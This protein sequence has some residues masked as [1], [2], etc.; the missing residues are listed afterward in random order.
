MFTHLHVH[1]EYSLLDGCCRIGQL[2]HKAKDLG[3]HS[4]AI[5]DH[6][7]MYGVIDFYKAAREEGIKP[8]LGCEVYV[9]PNDFRS[10]DPAEKSNC[11]LTLLAR[12][13]TGY[14]NLIQLVTLANLE[15]FYYKPRIDKNLLKKYAEGL[16]LLSGC[17]QGELGRLILQ[18]RL[19]DTRTAAKWYKDNFEHYYIEIQKHPMADIE[20]INENLVE[21]ARDLN[22]PLVATNDVHYVN[23]EDSYIHDVLLCIGTNTTINE[24]KRLKMAGAY[25]Y[26]K[27]PQEM[28]EQYADMPDAL[29]N[30]ATIADLCNVEIEFGKPHLPQVQVPDG[31]TSHAYLS[32]LCW[33]G[34]RERWPDADVEAEKRLAYELD[35]IEKT[36]FADYF[37]VVHDLASFVRREG[38]FFGVRGSAAAS[39]ALYCLGITDINPL[40]YKLVFERFLNIERREMPDID[41]DFQDDRREEVI[42]YVNS[43]YG[44]DH[45]A[46]I[47]TFGTLGARAAIRDVG[48]A[49]GL[50]YGTV[51]QVAKLIPVRPNIRLDDAM[52][53]VKELQ[54]MYDADD[55]IRKLIDTAKKLEGVSR[56][57]STHAAGVVISRDTLTEY[58]PLQRASKD[59]GQQS[60]MTQF[61]M[62]NVAKL[63]LLKLDFLGLAN[64]TLL[65]KAKEV[66]QQNHGIEI[67]FLTMPLDDQKTFELLASG[68]TTGI[69]Q[70]EG[71]GM[72]RYIK[73]LK[74]T[75][76]MDIS[77][78]VALYRPGPMEHIP[79]FIRAKH[80][81]E[82]VR[83]P[84]E[85]LIPILEDTYGIIVYQDQVLFVVQRFAGYSLGR[86]D[87]I[88]KAMGK[89][90]AE[91]MKK[92][93]QNFIDGAKLKGY[94]EQEAGAVFALIE[95]FA[96]YAFNKAHS[97]S[98]ARIAYQT[99]YLKANYPIE[100]MTAFLNTYYDKAE[101]LVTA[102]AECRRINLDV[103]RPDVNHSYASFVIE[104]DNGNRGIRFGM[105]SI[106][107]VGSNAVAPI[108]AARD[109][110]GEFTSI[111]DFCRRVDLRNVNKKVIESLIK[112]GAFDSLGQ[113]GS[114]LAALE[115]IMSLSQREQKQK[116]SGQSSMFDL[117][118]QNV[119][120]PLP[121]LNLDQ[122]DVTL[123]EKL[124][125]EKELMGV[126]FSEHPLAALASK[127]AEYSSVLCGE[128]NADMV[129]EKVVVAG[130]VTAVR[131]I[132]TKNN[133]LFVVATFEDLNGSIEVTVWS[134]VYQQSQDL[135]IEGSILV[136]EGTIKVRE[137]RVSVN[138]TRVHKYDPDM[139]KV[140]NG[141]STYKA[142]PRK[143][144]ISIEQTEDA[145]RDRTNLQKILEILHRYPGRD[146]V[147]LSIRKNDKVTY[148]DLPDVHVDCS[149]DLIKELSQ[150]TQAGANCF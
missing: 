50:N 33:R 142:P 123:Q 94:T 11:H 22:I 127:L 102:V 84:H 24:E 60:A 10:R 40:T 77:A 122:F 119:S 37:L 53:E 129:G 67:D 98:Y 114:L 107:N 120:V 125:W 74:P 54:D 39:L 99:A 131:L 83:Y 78:M 149:N 2:I 35:V 103:R 69:F 140:S 64:L 96:G 66:I 135:W 138:C 27:T 59:S 57:S 14:R 113:R 139:N 48:R 110:G 126:Y 121:A 15:G 104:K 89:K 85:D 12:N 71:P 150:I 95:P 147:Q 81:L 75:K 6:G 30:T 36:Q 62:E 87:I 5:T 44:T 51:D 117:F 76:F 25:F 29:Q 90:N 38:I 9:A 43:K 143:L 68:E 1:T 118:G 124:L 88:R 105:A 146:A 132:T 86:A 97:V 21:I 72:R 70:L 100:Y 61:S 101:R 28:K 93:K 34:L 133:R 55:Q 42:A 112:A 134:D 20:K 136:I 144:K 16:V 111:E 7:N 49:L 47:I 91:T 128:I 63:G 18:N 73:E 23:K 13:H 141:K 92:E 32:V 116:E 65:A 56:H 115:R 8:I 137:D 148:M 26:L 3:M 82:S 52:L 106:K 108:I 19:E 46:H 41:L 4:L 145:D 17:A 80:G 45:V 130:M 109:Q 58:L 31:K 79:T